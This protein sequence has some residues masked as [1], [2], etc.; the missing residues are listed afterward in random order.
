MHMYMLHLI[1]ESGCVVQYHRKSG[2]F[3]YLSENFPCLIK[4]DNI[5]WP[6]AQHAF[7]ASK[8]NPASPEFHARREEIRNETSMKRVMELGRK[9]PLN[10]DFH[11]VGHKLNIMFSITY[12]KFIQNPQ[13]AVSLLYDTQTKPI[14]HYCDDIFWGTSRPASGEG[15]APSLRPNADE[16]DER[17][18]G[19]RSAAARQW[20][21]GDNWNGKILSVVRALIQR[22]NTLDPQRLKEKVARYCREH[23]PCPEEFFEP[24]AGR[25]HPHTTKMAK[26]TVIANR[27]RWGA[28]RSWHERTRLRA[29]EAL[30][31]FSP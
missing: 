5:D 17:N 14:W 2:P 23:C 21:S 11:D 16:S 24:P 6:S 28:A 13:L 29:R 8:V 25:L 7:Q 30:K 27:F 3:P 19:K 18:T 10:P 22:E 4:Y 12:Q 31:E 1:S 9:V 26:G 15:A 20:W